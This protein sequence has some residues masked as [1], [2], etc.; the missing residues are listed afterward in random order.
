MPLKDLSQSTI[1]NGETGVFRVNKGDILF[2]PKINAEFYAKLGIGNPGDVLTV[3]AQGLPSWGKDAI[4][5]A[6][7]GISVPLNLANGKIFVGN[8]SN[9]AQ[10]TTLIEGSGIDIDYDVGGADLTVKVKR[11]YV[12]R[13]ILAYG[14]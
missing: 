14:V 6:I 5:N 11:G 9:L 8:A 2:A 10:A 13:R 3:S 7:T 4:Q 1:Q 12:I